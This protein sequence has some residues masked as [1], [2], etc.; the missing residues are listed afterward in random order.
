MRMPSLPAPRLS[1]EEQYLVQKLA[2]AATKTN[3]ISSFHYLGRGDAYRSNC[4]LNV[5]MG[6]IGDA[7]RIFLLGTEINKDH[8]V[9]GFLVHN[10]RHLKKNPGFPDHGEGEQFNGTQG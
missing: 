3:N 6:N 7:S 4:D 5:P 1:N 2:R 9:T 8:A 10:T